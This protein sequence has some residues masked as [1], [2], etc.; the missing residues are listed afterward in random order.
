MNDIV[1]RKPA[2][3]I[4]KNLQFRQTEPQDAAFVLSLRLDESKSRHISGTDPDV[5]KQADWIRGVYDDSR[6]AYFI[7]ED[8]DGNSVGTVRLY[9]P[10][11]TAFCWGSWILGDGKPPSAAIESTL[12]VYAYGL[13]CGFDRSYFDVRR[14]NVKVWQYHER[15]GAVRVRED[16][17]DYFYSMSGA[18]ISQVL[19]RYKGR[20]NDTIAVQLDADDLT[21]ELD[22][23]TM[24]WNVAGGIYGSADD[25][26]APAAAAPG[27]RAGSGPRIS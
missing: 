10:D 15:M 4:G 12:M 14:E 5:S 21:A 18:A 19:L 11:G 8:R 27:T 23:G 13:F 3:V 22:L 20:V 16:G 24:D 2:K 7:I 9:D 25:R 1:F 26:A 17:P 6:Q